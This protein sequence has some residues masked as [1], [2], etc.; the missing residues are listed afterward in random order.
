MILQILKSQVNYCRNLKG[1]KRLSIMANQTTISSSLCIKKSTNNHHILNPPKHAIPAHLGIHARES[2]WN[3]EI[4][5][6]TRDVSY[7]KETI[8]PKHLQ[9]I[10]ALVFF[11]KNMK[12]VR[13]ERTLFSLSSNIFTS[14]RN[15]FNCTH[16]LE[17]ANWT[18]TSSKTL[19]KSSYWSSAS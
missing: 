16:K 17:S 13:P 3:L 14:K 11:K 2:S 5:L 18:S 4:Q 10:L 1:A 19:T 6:H 8:I 15:H 7:N 9:N 12:C